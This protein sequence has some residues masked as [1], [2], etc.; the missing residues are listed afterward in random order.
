MYVIR[1]YTT[2]IRT[3]TVFPRKDKS[4]HLVNIAPDSVSANQ[5]IC[6][7][8][9]GFCFLSNSEWPF[10]TTAK[11]FCIVWKKKPFGFATVDLDCQLLRQDVSFYY[12]FP[13]KLHF[14]IYLLRYIAYTLLLRRKPTKPNTNRKTYQKYRNKATVG[15][16]IHSC[17]VFHLRTK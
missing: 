7:Q 9:G 10:F 13:H 8:M 17:S 2:I 5:I 15:Q 14:Q 16:A 12:R 1:Y 11:H 3:E 4:R 6:L